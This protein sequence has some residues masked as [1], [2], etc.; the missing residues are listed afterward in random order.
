MSQ[1]NVIISGGGIAGLTTA[2]CLRNIGANVSIIEKSRDYLVNNNYIGLWNP[3]LNCL[4]QIL[5]NG[6][7]ENKSYSVRRAG[8][9]DVKGNWLMEPIIGL[10]LAPGK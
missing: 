5:G 1:L 7:I 4:S 10:K 9:R 2:I 6:N 3:A 8:Y